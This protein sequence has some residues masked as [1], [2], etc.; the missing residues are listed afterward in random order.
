MCRQTR[1]SYNEHCT[2]R[3]SNRRLRNRKQ[4]TKNEKRRNEER[5]KKRRIG[6][7]TADVFEMPRKREN[8][9][10]GKPN[11]FARSSFYFFYEISSCRPLRLHKIEDAAIHF[12]VAQS[13]FRWRDV[14]ST[15]ARC[16]RIQ[17]MNRLASACLSRTKL[18]CPEK[19]KEKT[20]TQFNICI[21]F[22]RC[23]K[24]D[25]KKRTKNERPTESIQ[26]Q[27]QQPLPLQHM[28]TLRIIIIIFAREN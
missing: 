24:N 1:T 19:T 3:T 26:Q 2:A 28:I 23:A 22:S 4:K 10:D 21:S 25:E 11:G 7:E 9:I 8:F 27:Q 12:A 16:D 6:V 20:K 13:D 5:R 14:R 15:Y 17:P 18:N